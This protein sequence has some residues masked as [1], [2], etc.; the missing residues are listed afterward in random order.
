MLFKLF[1][2]L[3]Q[4]M[5]EK[6]QQ[7]REFVSGGKVWYDYHFNTGKDVLNDFYH[8]YDLKLDMQKCLENQH[9]A[10]A[11]VQGADK[12]IIICR[13]LHTENGVATRGDCLNIILT[14][15]NVITLRR[16]SD[17]LLSSLTDS[18]SSMTNDKMKPE[19]I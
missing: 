2:A 4:K 7:V 15:T 19:M 6:K 12:E 9:Q 14:P 17:N 1:V 16:S 3:E 18:F 10:S 11:I 5:V 13:Y 8:K